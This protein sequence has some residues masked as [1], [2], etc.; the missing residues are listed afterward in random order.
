MKPVML[1]VTLLAPL[2]L[3]NLSQGQTRSAATDRGA[4]IVSGGFS[5]SSQGGNLYEAVDGSRVTTV[6]IV[7]SLITF[8][9]P[10]LGIGG[11]FTYESLSQG[12]YSSSSMGVGPKIGYFI[13]SGGNVIPFAAG[14]VNLLFTG[15]TYGNNSDSMTGFRFKY[16]GG[17]LIRKDHLA[18]TIEATYFSDSYSVEQGGA[19]ESI[20]GNIFAIS[21][22][23]AGFLYK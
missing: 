20:S 6:L 15:Y 12:D 8:L 18:F 2:L 14:G 19:S 22:G 13:D 17:V 4:S 10:G 3:L 16:G 7:P 21:V 11:D 23:F 1:V 5:Y 9:R